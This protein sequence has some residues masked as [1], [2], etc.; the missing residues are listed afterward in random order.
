M[1]AV[2]PTEVFGFPLWRPR[3]QKLFLRSASLLYCLS[4]LV[5]SLQILGLLHTAA[6]TLTPPFVSLCSK[7]WCLW[8]SAHL[9]LNWGDWLWWGIGSQKLIE[10]TGV[11]TPPFHHSSHLFFLSVSRWWWDV[12]CF[13]FPHIYTMGSHPFLL[14]AHSNRSSL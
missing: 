10:F 14:F 4:Y 8:T 7:G 9:S 2:C 13:H 11:I 3:R 6:T 12:H 5:I 1:F